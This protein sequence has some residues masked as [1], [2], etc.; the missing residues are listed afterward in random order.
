MSFSHT[1]RDICSCN[2]LLYQFI[3]M[4]LMRVLLYIVTGRHL[5]SSRCPPDFFSGTWAVTFSN[6]VHVPVGLQLT[7]SGH[8]IQ[9]SS[10]TTMGYVKHLN[11][12]PESLEGSVVVYRK[13]SWRSLLSGGRMCLKIQA[14]TSTSFSAY[15]NKDLVCVLERVGNTNV[16]ARLLIGD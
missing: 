3:A 4:L 2:C 12:N 10:S 13:P 7:I 5:S 9:A 11:I 16:L 6:H 8:S 1:S 14:C 15:Y